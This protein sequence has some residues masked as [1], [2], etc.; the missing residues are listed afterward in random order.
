MEKDTGENPA[1]RYQDPHHLT[2][3]HPQHEEKGN[4]GRMRV[5]LENPQGHPCCCQQ[6]IIS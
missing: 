1:L 6:M 3:H 5:R 4:V 2:N